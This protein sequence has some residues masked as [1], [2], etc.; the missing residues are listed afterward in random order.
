MAT[1]AAPCAALACVVP[2]PGPP[3]TPRQLVLYFQLIKVKTQQQLKRCSSLN[4]A[5]VQHMQELHA[6]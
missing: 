1:P 2:W 4:L 3:A 6:V 5:K